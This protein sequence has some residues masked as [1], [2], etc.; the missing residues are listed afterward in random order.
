MKKC[1]LLKVDCI[2]KDCAWFMLPKVIK[3]NQDYQGRCAIFVLAASGVH[4]PDHAVFEK[5]EQ[6]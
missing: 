6:D 5:K 2:K 3:G 4:G 1:P